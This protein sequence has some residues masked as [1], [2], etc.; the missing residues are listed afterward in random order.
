MTVGD[1]ELARALATSSPPQFRRDIQSTLELQLF[2]RAASLT[3]HM[4]MDCRRRAEV[5]RL[6][7]HASSSG[8]PLQ[9]E[10]CVERARSSYQTGGVA[11]SLAL[12]RLQDCGASNIESISEQSHRQIEVAIPRAM[13]FDGDSPSA[14][15]GVDAKLDGRRQHMPQCVPRV[16]TEIGLIV[17]CIDCEHAVRTRQC[18]LA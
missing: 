18:K 17:R 10:R 16:T 5:Q 7:D 14:S 11:P 13:Q 3:F 4:V 6:C 12:H 9:F 8:R 2:H 15:R 1:E